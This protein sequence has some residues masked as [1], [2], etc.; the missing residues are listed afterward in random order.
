MYFS[1]LF[2]LNLRFSIS[3]IRWWLNSELIEHILQIIDMYNFPS[4]EGSPNSC[5]QGKAG[6]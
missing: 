6:T 2:Q 1:Y 4:I 5:T 3:R